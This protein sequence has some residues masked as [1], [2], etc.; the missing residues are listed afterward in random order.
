MYTTVPGLLHNPRSR[1]H[2]HYLSTRRGRTK[3]KIEKQL[4]EI[5]NL[6]TNSGTEDGNRIEQFKH[7]K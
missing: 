4:V 7:I 2:G 6:E 1:A 3:G 5:E